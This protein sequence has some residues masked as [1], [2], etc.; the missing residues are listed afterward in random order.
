MKKELLLAKSNI[1]KGKGITFGLISLVLLAAAF[2]NLVLVIFTDINTNVSK[3]AQ[4]LNSSDA[5]LIIE[6][7]SH[8]DGTS[9]LDIIT[10]DYINE[11]INKDEVTDYEI[12]RTFGFDTATPYGDGEVNP[13]I[14]FEKRD[15]I[16]GQ[17]IDKTE[18]LEEDTSITGRYIYLPYQ[19][20][21]GGNIN[22]GDNY[23]LAISGREYNFKVKGYLNNV[24]FGSYNLGTVHA[25]VDDTTY[26][27]MQNNTKGKTD[28]VIVKFK[29]KQGVNSTKFIN[30]MSRTFTN[31]DSTFNIFIMTLEDSIFNRTF[32]AFIIGASFLAISIIILLIVF[33]MLSN[34]ISNYIKENIKT[35][36][37]IK[38]LGFTSKNIKL[39]FLLQFM[40]LSAIG[41]IL[42]LI[43]SYVMIPFVASII[44]MQVGIPYTV[45]FNSMCG[46]TTIAGVIS[47]II[48][49]VLFFTRKTKKIEPI[50]A[51]RSG[52]TTHN[53]KKNR[54]PIEKSRLPLN[55]NL[56]IKTMFTNF[57]QNVITFLVV[58][59]LVF[60][61]VISLVMLQ[62]FSIEPK[63]SLLTIE[64]CDGVVIADKDENKDI[65]KYME[66]KGDITDVRLLSSNIVEADDIKL[67]TY[68][69]NNDASI[70]NKDV[71]YEG[72]LPKYDN[73]IVVSGKYAKNYSHNIGDELEVGVGNVRDKFIITGFMQTSNNAGQE[74]I[75]IENGAKKVFK[76]DL[77][78]V[79]FF[80][81]K[82][83]TDVNKCLDDIK[84]QFGDR[85]SSTT[86]YEDAME[87]GLS[88]FKT[89]SNMMV[90]SMLTISALIILL[91][92]YLL[93][94]TLINN[95][96]KDYGILKAIGFTSKNVV[97]Q[98]AI[99]F[100]PSIILSVILS[101]IVST[102][103][104][105]PYLTL[106]MNSFGIMKATFV[107][108]IAY[109]VLMG[110]GFIVISYL[111]AFL[112]SRKIRKIEPYNLLRGE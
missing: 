101:C 88:I 25:I 26:A 54:A 55:M 100:M 68:V 74:A 56:A 79:Y 71:C 41:I 93:I 15:T 112:L 37:A 43:L 19:Y 87:A 46:V 108:P 106:M 1:R 13:F 36:G 47:I 84:N 76:N 102:Y 16:L 8:E 95:K 22:V 83:G 97:A 105:N 90:I 98:N 69:L 7:T 70:K 27:E 86:N 11:I 107:M 65:L 81:V 67:Q 99:S 33:L 110:V 53:F 82:E 35:L 111:F 104:A 21:T 64:M 85:I 72:R 109:I 91:V 103:L 9:N 96:K 38:A 34:S 29:L 94:K 20:H 24:A 51:L 50:T 75:L 5:A 59:F 42:G 14:V 44:T 18:I 10:D 66:N 45:T 92:L 23:K 4:K 80:D 17:K 31:T 62:N 77:A 2:F 40:I 28:T 61:G 48:L 78:K 30:D 3:Y 73:E 39:S 60:T 32:I 58:F 6:G 52:I 57:K 89:I 12:M 63:A 49:A